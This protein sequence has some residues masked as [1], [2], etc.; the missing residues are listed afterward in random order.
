MN[1]AAQ[2]SRMCINPDDAEKYI[3]KKYTHLG[4]GE[5]LRLIRAIR[6]HARRNS[7][8]SMGKGIARGVAK[9][10]TRGKA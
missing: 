2:I 5:R 10:V 4:P 3:A 6:E 7:K 1:V 9:L 8:P